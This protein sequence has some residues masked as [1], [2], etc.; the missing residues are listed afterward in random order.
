M[1]DLYVLPN[2]MKG[3]EVCP[4]CRAGQHSMCGYALQGFFETAGECCCGREYNLLAHLVAL[5]KEYGQE[6]VASTKGERASKEVVAP[7]KPAK[8]KGDSGYI[9]PDAWGS[10]RDIGTLKDP[11]STGYKRMTGLYEQHL[12]KRC[13]W[14][15]LKHAGSGPVRIVGCM[16][17]DATEIHHAPDKNTLNNA[18][19]SMGVG[20]WEEN[21]WM[22]CSSCH[23]AWHAANDALYPPRNNPKA[24]TDFPLSYDR[25][26]DQAHAWLPLDG[27]YELHDP[28]TLAD[29]AELIELQERRM[30]D[31]ERRGRTKIGRTRER[32]TIVT[33]VWDDD[34][35]PGPDPAEG[36]GTA[37]ES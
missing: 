11:Q 1:S 24:P 12:G 9:H 31:A 14:A 8:K 28:D 17:N 10:D 21:V 25:I 16:G 3:G 26:R 36:G 32:G 4:S 37:A 18:K 7:A 13:E 35:G 27:K 15:L 34:E 33:D 2:G 29:P 19:A 22:I 30:K 5:D 6:I 23:N 20:D